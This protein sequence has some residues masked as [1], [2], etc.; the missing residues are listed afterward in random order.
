VSH[1]VAVTGANGF[2]G[3]HLIHE[4]LGEEHE[5]C[6][7][8]R[9][10]S[11]T[12]GIPDGAST[13]VISDP[14]RSECWRDAL[15]HCDTVI[16]LI[17]LAHAAARDKTDLMKRFREVNVGI[18][19]CVVDACFHNGVR[20]LIYLSSIK[21]VGE[22]TSEPYTEASECLPE[23]PYGESKREAEK[24]ILERTQGAP[25]EASVVRPPVVYGPGVKGNIVRMMKLVRSGFPL[26][27]RCL[28]ARRSMVYVGN[29]VDALCFMVKSQRPVEGILH[30]SD[31]EDA[32]T[33][34][35]AFLELG[36]VMG[37]RVFEVPVP[38]TVVRMM[39]RFVGM[40]EE[41]NRLTR[42]LTTR[43][44]RLAD[45]ELDW[46]PPHSMQEG[47]AATVQWFIDQEADS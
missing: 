31:A 24:L 25:I 23:N 27:I 22:G 45:E 10:D 33:T 3:R 36:K 40:G 30:I 32:P 2:I 41:V 12:E 34:R 9:S 8:V 19:D 37:K 1:R 18:T 17:G 43:G 21:A 38:A 42:S 15:V 28:K 26:P 5:V 14:H 39:G 20:R 6:A 46:R 11:A 44:T 4:L 47:L 7:V 16:H 35:E 29:L 13:F